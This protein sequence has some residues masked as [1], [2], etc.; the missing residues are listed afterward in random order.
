MTCLCPSSPVHH[1]RDWTERRPQAADA[2]LKPGGRSQPHPEVLQR[3]SPGCGQGL[4]AKLSANS[5]ALRRILRGLSCHPAGRS[6][7]LKLVLRS[8]QPGYLQL[9]YASGVYGIYIMS[10]MDGGQLLLI[11]SPS[12]Y[13]SI[14]TAL[15]KV[16]LPGKQPH[17]PDSL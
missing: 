3:G 6:F 12:L 8:K 15:D 14:W 5:Q 10:G 4:Q 17:F 1:P 13:N 11:P 2:S 16:E 9:C 7:P